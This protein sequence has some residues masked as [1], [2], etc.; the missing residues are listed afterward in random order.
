MDQF[1][2]EI[3]V[4]MITE[5]IFHVNTIYYIKMYDIMLIESIFHVNMIYY[6]KMY[7]IMLIESIVAETNIII[8]Q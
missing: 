2:L 4:S 1:C 6:I 7:D 5:A 3:Y 8:L